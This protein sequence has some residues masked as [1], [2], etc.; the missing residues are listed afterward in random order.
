MNVQEEA[1]DMTNMTRDPKSIALAYIDACGRKDHEAVAN[2]VAPDLEFIGMTQTVRSAETYLTVLR[3][4][5]PIWVRSDVKKAFA[6]GNEVCVLYDFV[7]DT[8][9]GAVRCVEWLR[10]E[11]G[12]VRWAKL[13]F[14]RPSF[15]PALEELER[16][17]VRAA[18]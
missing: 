15:Q 18:G 4:L 17:A 8:A 11:D 9:A 1:T 7:T 12:R 5:A 16:R 6:D 3:R 2:L 13:L 10:I 14:D